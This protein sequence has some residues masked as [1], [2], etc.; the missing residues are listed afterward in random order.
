M[1]S[2]CVPIIDDKLFSGGRFKASAYSDAGETVNEDT[3]RVY[4]NLAWVLDGSSGLSSRT[5]TSGPT[6]A[7]WFVEQVERGLLSNANSPISLVEILK[8]AV[9]QASESF[10]KFALEREPHPHECPSCSVALIRASDDRIDYLVLGDVTIVTKTRDNSITVITDS[11]VSQ[12][13]KEITTK[14]REMQECEGISFIEARQ[15]VHS[16]LVKNRSMMNSSEGYWVLAL[17]PITIH[18]ALVGSFTTSNLTQVLLASDGFTRLVDTLKAF[19]NWD[20]L[21]TFVEEKGLASAFKVLRGLEKS[22]PE[23]LRYPRL[24]VSDDATAVFLYR[25]LQ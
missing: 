8:Q 18:H 19:D 12:L 10:A 24:K 9:V 16:L 15:R 14:I 17:D 1:S 23:C 21:L 25:H 13:D 4:E 22:D 7:S 11:T 20:E 6:D 5:L 2:S 3:G